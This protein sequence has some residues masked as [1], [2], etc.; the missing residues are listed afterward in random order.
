MTEMNGGKR[1]SEKKVVAMHA[2]CRLDWDCP[3]LLPFGL[4]VV[5]SVAGWIRGWS[6]GH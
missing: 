3:V 4:K 2:R 5:L 6:S 1:A